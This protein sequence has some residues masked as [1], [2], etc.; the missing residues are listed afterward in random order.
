EKVV[1]RVE[2]ERGAE[3]G[4]PPA[5]QLALTDLTEQ[6]RE[7]ERRHRSDDRLQQVLA[8]SGTGAWVWTLAT[9][10]LEWDAQAQA[11]L[12]RPHD[13]NP[14]SFDVLKAAIHPDDAPRVRRAMHAALHL[15]QPLDLEHRVC[16]PD[17]AVHVVAANGKVQRNSLGEPECLMGL[18]RD[19]TDRYVAEQE[20]HYQ[21]TQLQRLLD[22]MPMVFARLSP[23]G[24]YLEMKGAGRHRLG[25]TEADAVGQSIF[26]LFPTLT[27]SFQRL[28]A[29]ESINFI[30]SAEVGGQSVSFQNYGFFDQ[31][32]QQ[33][34]VF[35]IDVTESEQ[36]KERLRAEQ[37]F[38]KRLL[39]HSID[40]VAAF[41]HT[42]RLTAWNRAMAALTG[43][44]EAEALGQDVM[45]CL[46]FE[47]TSPIGQTVTALLHGPARP[48]YNHAFTWPQSDR[49]VE[50][51]AT[52]L[53]HADGAPGTGGLLLLRDVTE[54]NRL[55]THAAQ[56]KA[57][58]QRETFRLVLMAQ[59]VE[60]KRIAEALHNGVGQLLYATKL[61]LED[62]A[63][64]PGAARALA[65]LEDAIKATR[66]V[67]FELTPG[68]LEDFG[69]AVALQ[70]LAR[71][72][73]PDKLRLHVYLT[74]LHQPLPK[75]LNV[76]IYRMVQ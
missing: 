46:P 35:A 44:T 10:A 66:T 28:L 3:P 45:A 15:G 9:N 72:I 37:A 56:L 12:G 32:R 55:H 7:A 52:P 18:V 74:G 33:G 39:N 5:V 6:R 8:A 73:P 22:N 64:T 19:V 36:V 14:T 61:H 63:T 31:Q 76:A 53:A 58:Q 71:N 60:R 11:C 68:I 48:R 57:R 20:L 59:E 16:W 75:V 65:L 4:G 30:G 27:D 49:D 13:P 51:T 43:R 42:G 24:E 41:D 67:S 38:T 62:G 54:R 26:D 23:A 21:N 2:A 47:P 70:K 50:L 34:V 40:G 1:A 17:G 25:M 29:G 69:L